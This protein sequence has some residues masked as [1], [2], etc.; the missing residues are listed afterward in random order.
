[1]PEK[2]KLVSDLKPG[3]TKPEVTKGTGACWLYTSWSDGSPACLDG[4]D[5]DGCAY[6]AQIGG[7]YAYSFQPG[8]TC[9]D[10]GHP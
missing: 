2:K 6:H 1:M 4:V 5:E 7:Y 3:L 8:D 9:K 10:P